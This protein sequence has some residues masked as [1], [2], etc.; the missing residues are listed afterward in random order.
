MET[1]LNNA[2]RDF[3][4]GLTLQDELQEASVHTLLDK[5]IR[6]TERVMQTNARLRTMLADEE[7]YRQELT[8]AYETA[9]RA[10][11]AK[12]DFLSKM[13]HDIRTPMNA[14]IG[15]TA[16]AGAHLDNRD[17][18]ADCLSKINVSSRHLLSL[19]NEVLDMS[20]I[21]SGKLSLSEDAFNLSDLLD[22]LLDMVH[23]SVEECRHELTV[24][25]H[26]LQHE[27]V[28][29]DSLRIRQAFVNIVGN[30]VKYTPPGGEI[31]IDILEHPT[32]QAGRGCYEFVFRDN[33]IGMSPE[34]L[35]RIFE[36]FER[37][38]D[39]R[40]NRIQG[41]GLG[42][43]ITRNII[44]MMD[45]DIQVESE[46]GK[47]TCFTVTIYLRL[48]D[49]D[50][51]PMEELQGASV[52]VVDD[53]PVCCETACVML[54]E[55]GMRP[56]SVLSGEEALELLE[57]A[58]R[59]ENAYFCILLDWKMPGTDG[60][61]LTKRIRRRLGENIP[62]II[63]SAYGWSEI[64]MDARAAGAHAFVSKPLFPS[65][66]IRLFRDMISGNV[67]PEQETP[68]E[69][70]ARADFGSRRVLLV[71]D[72]EL[73]REIAREILSMT[74]LTIE[75]AVNGREAVDMVSAAPEGYYDMIFMD[76]QMPEMNGYEATVA[77]RSLKRRDLRQLPIVA[78]TANAFPEDVQAAR[79]CGMNE[80]I[81]KPLDIPQL[82]RTLEY[83]LCA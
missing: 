3:L 21:E 32:K 10:N 75:E 50:A 45:G 12:T 37:A 8:D 36:P 31:S 60:V 57:A 9:N 17:K 49:V 71:E 48:Q 67:Q 54:E 83:W 64:E 76:I 4:T 26:H 73:N 78:M 62:I 72:N 24:H 14:I 42:M 80:H 68:L 5:V 81:A 58:D 74:G 2:I 1:D 63:M 77:I 6:L 25:I 55:L 29:G 43:A 59:R 65:R 15:M 61:E 30:A 56:E 41:T 69:E 27:Q 35:E 46:P 39:D 66:L 33:G 40:V 7:K 13:S 51:V 23:P 16:I 19:I 70:M 18:V 52:L 47:G 20:K 38:E 34:F 11:S 28:I 22:D 53:D 82:M 79:N 44:H